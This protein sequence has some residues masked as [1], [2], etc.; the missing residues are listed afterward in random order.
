LI[1]LIQYVSRRNPDRYV[2]RA[3]DLRARRLL[4][5]PVVD[6]REGSE[7]M[8]GFPV[9]RA[10]SPDGRWAYTLYDGADHP[11]IHAL[12]T[13]RR[14]AV[15]I[16]LHSLASRRGGLWG[17]RLEVGPG[18]GSPLTVEAGN[19]VLASVD[20]RTFRVTERRAAARR[21][22]ETEAVP[23]LLVGPGAGAAVLLLAAVAALG[24]GRRGRGAAAQTSSE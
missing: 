11:F 21:S 17:L 24:G 16:D 7:P 5:E 9:T 1:Y 3:Y 20:T 19:R 14:Q 18:G 23:W 13:E 6:P 15:C 10:G 12:D 8:N 4:S 22:P 2:V